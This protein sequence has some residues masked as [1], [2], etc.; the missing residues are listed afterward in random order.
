MDKNTIAGLVIIFLISRVRV[1]S[2]W[3]KCS[4]NSIPLRG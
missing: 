3:P 2:N 4:G 1:R